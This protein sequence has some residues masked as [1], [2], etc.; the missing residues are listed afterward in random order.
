MF[1]YQ[2]DILVFLFITSRKLDSKAWD[3]IPCNIIKNQ[4]INVSN[5]KYVR[6]TELSKMIEKT[7]DGILG[8]HCVQK[9]DDS[10]CKDINFTHF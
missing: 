3:T 4:Q 2:L 5:E 6:P 8:I 1:G 7:E 9:L 10:S